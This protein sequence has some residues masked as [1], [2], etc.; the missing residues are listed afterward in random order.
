M[1]NRYKNKSK[2]RY[3]S[4]KGYRFSLLDVF[5]LIMIFSIIGGV[6]RLNLKETKLFYFILASLI[7]IIIIKF[8]ITVYLKHLIRKRYIKSRIYEIDAMKGNEFESFLKAH[9][10]TQG[11][12]V[13]LTP[14]TNDYGADL[15]LKK[16]GFVTVVQAKRY[17][18]KIGN[19]AIQ[20]I[21][22]AKGYYNA[23]SC[24]VITNSFYTS[25]ANKLAQA[26]NVVL[27]DRNDLIVNFRIS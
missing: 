20:E 24:L 2:R 10:E 5:S 26:N 8:M 25:N 19:K 1:K 15:V 16:N 21:I 17:K 13:S 27:W 4:R 7:A 14:Q 22:G 6:Y 9:F 18:N 3:R 11:Y 12:K 23:D